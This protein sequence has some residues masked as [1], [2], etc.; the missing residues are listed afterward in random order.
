MKFVLATEKNENGNI[1]FQ[2]ARV[3]K[4]FLYAIKAESG[5][6][7]HVDKD[8]ILQNKESIINLGVDKN[9]GLYYVEPKKPKAKKYAVTLSRNSKGHNLML[10]NA[11][12]RWVYLINEG[13][14]VDITNNIAL[15]E[16]KVKLLLD[17]PITKVEEKDTV[18]FE[19]AKKEKSIFVSVKDIYGSERY[20]AL[21]INTNFLKLSK[22]MCKVQRNNGY[23]ENEEVNAVGF[24]EYIS[25]N[26]PI[27]LKW[28][29]MRSKDILDNRGTYESGLLHQYD[30]AC[31]GLP[32]Y[33]ISGLSVDEAASKLQEHIKLLQ[34]IAGKYISTAKHFAVYSDADLKK[35]FEKLGVDLLNSEQSEK[36]LRNN[37]KGIIEQRLNLSD[38]YDGCDKK[39]RDM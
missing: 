20:F 28:E 22:V 29:I 7:G 30:T 25:L 24:A 21:W 37:M 6:K 13:N 16:E 27:V 4:D 31:K 15:S 33:H 35:D 14:V 39:L 34:A 10:S 9:G 26:Y 5:E 32:L 17:E 23:Y 12:M 36:S 1:V 3:G 11:T 19:K 38:F 8:W 18:A 2:K